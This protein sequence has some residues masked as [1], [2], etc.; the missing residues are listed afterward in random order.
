MY[1]CYVALLF[2]V[3]VC[4]RVCVCVVSF[5]NLAFRVSLVGHLP[6]TPIMTFWPSIASACSI[7]GLRFSCS[8]MFDSAS[9]IQLLSVSVYHYTTPPP[10]FFFFLPPPPPPPPGHSAPIPSESVGF[11]IIVVLFTY[12][13]LVVV[14][15]IT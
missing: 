5:T 2:V 13:V 8:A 4:V 7:Q 3:C 6:I 15:V 14:P 10:F 11:R 12:W 9:S 1:N